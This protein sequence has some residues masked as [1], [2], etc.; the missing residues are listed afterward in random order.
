[1]ASL[2]VARPW[3]RVTRVDDS[4]TRIEEPF[5]V[6]AHAH[7]DHL[8]SAHEFAECWAHELEPTEA[9]GQGTLSGPEL[10][11]ILGAGDSGFDPPGEVM[12]SALPYAG[13]DVER[14]ALHP[15]L[16]SRRVRSAEI[17]DAEG[18]RRARPSGR[19]WR[20]PARRLPAIPRGE[21]TRRGPC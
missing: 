6:V 14:Y 17:A 21:V 5:A 8:G 4:I 1:M 12:L 2:P 10:L 7:L 15:V 11:E 3:F 9:L 20:S 18:A 13:Y 16:P 19:P